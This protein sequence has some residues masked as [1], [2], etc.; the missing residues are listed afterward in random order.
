MMGNADTG[1]TGIDA[2]PAMDASPGMDA[3]ELK[4][5]AWTPPVALS[6]TSCSTT[7]TSTH[8]IACARLSVPLDWAHPS[9][10]APIELALRR[11]EA[12][13]PDEK[14]GVLFV[15]PGGPGSAARPFAEA[16]YELYPV[17]SEHFDIVGL[18]WR[19]TGGSG[20]A[21]SCWTDADFE[22]L[23]AISPAD[24]DATKVFNDERMMACRTQLGDQ[25]VIQLGALSAA[26]DL[27]AARAALGEEQ[28]SFLGVSYGTRLGATYA[29]LFPARVRTMV[30]DSVVPVSWSADD[31]HQN[32][33]H[34]LD[35]ALDRFFTRCGA[36]AACPF[37][38]GQ[39]H[40]AVQSA[41]DAWVTGVLMTN[42]V[43]VVGGAKLTAAD[44]LA[45]VTG[46]L[47]G[48]E[49][50]TALGRFLRDAAAGPLPLDYLRQA[51]AIASKGPDGTYGPDTSSNILISCVD[52][53]GPGKASTSS[54]LDT[55]GALFG[56]GL[57]I[58]AYG[59]SSY[60]AC[61][62]LPITQPALPI[63]AESVAEKIYLV[64]GL[65]DPVTVPGNA[66]DLR[67][68]LRNNSW[69]D[70]FDVEGHA[71]LDRV[72]VSD[73][74]ES[75][76]FTPRTQP[77]PYSCQG[78]PPVKVLRLSGP[79][80]Y[81]R[82]T[83]LPAGTLSST[84]PVEL[85]LFHGPGLEQVGA[86]V[87]S[88]LVWSRSV[89]LPTLASAVDDIM[90][91]ASIPG[92]ATTENYLGRSTGNYFVTM[93]LSTAAFWR[94]FTGWD[95]GKGM[96]QIFPQD[97]SGTAAAQVA[98]TIDDPGAHIS[99]G[100]RTPQ[101]ACAISATV[102]VTD[103]QCRTVIYNVSPGPHTITMTANDGHTWTFS[104]EAKPSV[105]VYTAPSPR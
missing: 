17:L 22:R 31:F 82:A 47:Y 50:M 24:L 61:G 20:P 49:P 27:D 91:R 65:H 35:A 95:A 75:Y 101:G 51:D 69:L 90:V 38:G 25:T 77:G 105:T 89:G 53:F 92:V 18:D 19:G 48:P 30:L 46:D 94:G 28:I 36:A 57:R 103:G 80:A 67:T 62:V 83:G 55:V 63:H 54:F 45:I 98:I 21:L 9:S 60:T 59:A 71:M 32:A 79:R 100:R 88:T 64:N 13:L 26:R 23:R 70:T 74:I 1:M 87:T 6:W 3:A 86:T 5:D 93:S 44:A 10:S 16:V 12:R 4:E 81:T 42:Q 41:F 102:H 56:E 14:R 58:G 7:S 34:A 97:C 8:P 29:T 37:H 99:Y 52:G 72:G 33:D 66:D 78:I 15:N 39:G 43:P 2:A 96:V 73:R 76:F 11:A 85:S 68:Q 104:Y 40:D 84:T